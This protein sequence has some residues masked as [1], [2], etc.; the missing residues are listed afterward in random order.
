[1]KRIVATF[2][3]GTLLMGL[4]ATALA[5]AEWPDGKPK[6]GGAPV[7]YS[8]PGSDRANERRSEQGQWA[9]FYYDGPAHPKAFFD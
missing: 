3:L 5:N 1:M 4:S 6:D 8:N 2:V 7:I 9:K